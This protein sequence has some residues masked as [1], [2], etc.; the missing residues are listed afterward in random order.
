MNS[1]EYEYHEL[2]LDSSDATTSV[3]A[4]VSPLNLPL[5]NLPFQLNDVESFKVLQ[6]EIPFSYNVTAGGS[7]KIN[8]YPAW[9]VG[10]D[11]V[12]TPLTRTYGFP[13]SGIPSAQ[14]I[15][16]YMNLQFQFDSG[17]Q[18]LTGWG[19][20]YM[21]VAFEAGSAS[22]SNGI[23]KFRFKPLIPS[24]GSAL[25]VNLQFEIIISDQRSEDLLGMTIG[26]IKCPFFGVGTNTLN[27]SILSSRPLLITGPSY[28]YVSS[29]AVGNLCHTY[30]PSGAALLS[31]GVSSPQLAKIPVIAQPGH[32]IIWND[33]N[34]SHWFKVDRISS[35]T[36]ID[37]YC[38]LGNYG[39]YID[40]QGLN[41]SIKL[42]VLVRKQTRTTFGGN[43]GF[44]NTPSGYI[45]P[46]R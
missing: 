22:T 6:A 32:F 43:G 16:D 13:L 20:N 7:F 11:P 33:S 17:V 21:T 14:Q 4:D 1:D 45:F 27:L 38:Q 23:S 10:T 30:L 35:L 25:Q 46:N 15:A 28:I 40:F 34:T 2:Y 37:L 24:T 29:N 8:Y 39:G 26:T 31:G 12:P 44:T 42:G 19:S 41:F 36:Q 3:S 18:A 9:T 5:Y